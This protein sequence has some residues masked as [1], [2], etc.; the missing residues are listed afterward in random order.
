MFYQLCKNLQHLKYLV[1]ILFVFGSFKA[2]AQKVDSMFVHL[3][4]DSL[5][6][7]TYNYINVDGLLNNGRWL[8]L[9]S[10][11][12][13]FKSSHG[14]FYGN[15]LWVDTNFQ[16]DKITISTTLKA[17]RN[18]QKIFDMY[19]KKKLDDE[20]LLSEQDII[21]SSRKKKKKD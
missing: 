21:N 20:L 13:E 18:Q 17:D 14:T 3:Y 6:K 16:G 19:I 12:V 15:E 1:I 8:P 9:D 4:T 10:N 2:S 11:H 7:G 5:K